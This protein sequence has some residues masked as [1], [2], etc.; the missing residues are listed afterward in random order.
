MAMGYQGARIIVDSIDAQASLN[1][2]IFILTTGNM[3]LKTGSTKKFVQSFFL[4]EQPN[5][6]YV[7]NDCFRFVEANVSAA[8]PAA[9]KATE[10]VKEVPAPAAPVVAES[11]KEKKSEASKEQAPL[12]KAVSKPQPAKKAP[13]ASAEP[14]KNAAPSSWATLAAGGSD[15]WQNGVVAPTKAP[16]VTVSKDAPKEPARRDNNAHP[17]ASEKRGERTGFRGERD[18][19]SPRLDS[20][21]PQDFSR[22]VFIRN[23]GANP[24]AVA[25]RK[26]LESFG[27]ITSFD[28]NSVKS[29]AFVEFQTAQIAVAAV[30]GKISFNGATLNIDHRRPAG[31]RPG[32]NARTPRPQSSE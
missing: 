16:V 7:L 30:N 9:Q 12:E 10:P 23:L 19:R 5:G 25:L 11:V 2:G 1:G 8:A 14:P 22:S 28:F 4:A 21:P 29:Q 26:V 6:Y 32:G 31:Q 20:K 24:D 13:A 15:L 18:N 3:K 17:A 27:E